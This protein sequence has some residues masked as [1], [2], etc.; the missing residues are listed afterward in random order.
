MSNLQFT[1]VA[2]CFF[3]AALSIVVVFSKNPIVAAF[4][5]LMMFLGLGGIYFRLGSVF[6]ATIQVLVYAGAIA[7]L[8]VFILMLMN[9]EDRRIST[10]KKNYG[11]FAGIVAILSLFGILTIIIFNNTDYLVNDK[12]PQ[13]SMNDL[14][15]KLFDTYLVPF[16]LSTL[17]LLGAIVAVV[18]ISKKR[19]II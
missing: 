11:M 5:L 6:L 8:F 13:V 12:L 15:T 14:F 2:L 1:D 4:S 3:A 7:I 17:L 9:L 18:F 16:E 10:P 19:V